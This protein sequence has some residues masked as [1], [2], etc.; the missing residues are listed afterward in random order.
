MQTPPVKL[1]R[2]NYGID[3]PNVVRN[4]ALL[5]TGFVL[6]GVT[7]YFFFQSTRPGLALACLNLGLWPGCS[8][9][10]I[11]AIMLW[12][13]KVGKFR[14][15]DRLLDTI[16]WRGD[17]HVLDVGCG[18]GLLLIGAARRL[19]TGKAVGIDLW[20]KE[21]Q[22]GN[23]PEATLANIQLEGVADRVEIKDGDA[24]QLPFPDA[25]FDVVLSSWALHNIYA[26]GDRQRAV[27]EIAR[28]LK[29][30]GH[31]ALLDIRH[32]REYAEVLRECGLSGVR[33]SGPRFLFVIPT[34]AV[35][36][37]KPAS[38]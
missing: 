10:L 34:H 1:S 11:C 32:T 16:A 31:V 24:R 22:A 15:R 19:T 6:L 14:E 13:S 8:W 30:G 18:H 26:P 17:E 9:L 25:R 21:D 27:R 2:P 7:L 20:Q 36:G 38:T 23:S 35:L 4:L 5:G 33:R 28:V 12:G 29:P 37:T 3:A